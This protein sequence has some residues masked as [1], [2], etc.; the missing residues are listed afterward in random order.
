MPQVWP[1][2]PNT[3]TNRGEHYLPFGECQEVK[4]LFGK[5]IEE[6][7]QAEE[8]VLAFPPRTL[9]QGNQRTDEGK[10]LFTEVFQLINEEGRIETIILWRSS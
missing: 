5:L 9:S 1:K 2:K 7:H 8:K 3:N 6:W 4:S 10:F